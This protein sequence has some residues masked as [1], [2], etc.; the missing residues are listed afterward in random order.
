MV[1][2]SKDNLTGVNDTGEHANVPLKY[3]TA[4]SIMSNKVYNDQ[5]EKL[6]EIKDI[7][8]DITTAKIDYVIIEFGGFLGVGEKFFAVPYRLLSIDTERE[9]Y[10]FDQSKEVLEK[11]PG[12]DKDHWP[13]TNLH[14]FVTTDSYWGSFMG[15]NTGGF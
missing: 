14:G 2:L 11:A 10:I 7:M 5:N 4:T 6:G 13:H 15:P 1:T 3:L 8:I 9:A 12:F